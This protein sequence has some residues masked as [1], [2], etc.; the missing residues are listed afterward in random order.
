MERKNL[1][2]YNL[3]RELPEFPLMDLKIYKEVM[4]PEDSPSKKLEM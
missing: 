2:Y 4:A 1:D 3:R